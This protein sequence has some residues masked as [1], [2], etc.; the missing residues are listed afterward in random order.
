MLQTYL[1]DALGAMQRLSDWA[2][3]SRRRRWRRGQGPRG[4]GC[5]PRDGARRLGRPRLAPR[6]LRHQARQRH[7]LQASSLL[8]DDA[9]AHS[10][11]P[12]R[13]RRPQPLRHRLRPPPAEAAR[14]RRAASSSRCCSEWPRGR[15]S[16]SSR[17]SAGFCS[18]HPS[19]TRA[20]STSRSATS[21]AVSKRMPRTTTSCRPSSSSRPAM[22]SSTAR[23]SASC[24][25][26]PR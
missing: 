12:T 3:A 18:T 22:P 6:D 7:Q 14:G 4:Q 2:T 16:S 20:S 17:M 5:Q 8:G 11:R 10:R 19:S 9:R 23:S 26:W 13:S 21:S 25:R 15:P 24:R 1:P